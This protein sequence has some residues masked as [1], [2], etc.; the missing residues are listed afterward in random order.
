VRYVFFRPA[1]RACSL[2]RT[3]VSDELCVATNGCAP[4]SSERRNGS[5]EAGGVSSSRDVV[6]MSD[7]RSNTPAR[8]PRVR[9]RGDRSRSGRR[10]DTVRRRLDRLHASRGHAGSDSGCK[11]LRRVTF[12]KIPEPVGPAMHRSFFRWRCSAI[13]GRALSPGRA[14][15][16]QAPG[17]GNHKSQI[18]KTKKQTNSKT[19]ITNGDFRFRVWNLVLGPCLFF[20]IWDLVLIRRIIGS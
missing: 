20:G 17:S 14:G 4:G 1:L 8:S 10:L 5:D 7:R 13:R 6:S 15:S 2:R 9:N 11:A 18:T 19:Q 3:L 12:H 16:R